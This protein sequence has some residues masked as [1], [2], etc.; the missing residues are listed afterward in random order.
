M[1]NSESASTP[2][3]KPCWPTAPLPA[4][5]RDTVWSRRLRN[6]QDQTHEV[7]EGG[8]DADRW[9]RFARDC[10]F[11]RL[12]L[13]RIGSGRESRGRLHRADVGG[14]DPAKARRRGILRSARAQED[15]GDPVSLD[16]QGRARRQ[17]HGGHDRRARPGFGE[18]GFTL[19]AFPLASA[20]N[21]VLDLLPLALFP[22]PL[23]VGE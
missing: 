7:H 3:W 1:R 15:S 5:T 11:T 17:D 2:L 21:Q 16:R 10:W 23:V 14:A 20:R 18:I 22:S 9:T 12:W 8:K 4:S 19:R 13:G 6:K